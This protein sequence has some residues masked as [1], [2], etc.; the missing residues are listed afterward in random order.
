MW[1]KVG[2]VVQNT[3]KSGTSYM[4]FPLGAVHKLLRAKMSRHHYDSLRGEGGI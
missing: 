1:D 3:Q 4:K 2:W